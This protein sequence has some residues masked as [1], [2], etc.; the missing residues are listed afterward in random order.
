[1]MCSSDVSQPRR[2]NR[3]VPVSS[4]LYQILLGGCIAFAGC[5]NKQQAQGPQSQSMQTSQSQ[6]TASVSPPSLTEVHQAVERVFKSA[7]LIDESRSPSFV[8]GDFNGDRSEDI[9]VIITTAPGKVSDMNQQFPPWILKDPFINTEPGMTPLRVSERETLLALIHGYG[10]EGWH[11]SQA[12]QTYLLKNALGEKIET[13]TKAEVV[14]VNQG[15]KLPELKGDLISEI[16]RGKPGYLY[17]A[18]STYSWYDPET[19]QGEPIARPVHPGF[20]TRN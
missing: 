3:F 15:K 2:R 19:F 9:A 16:L 14:A 5:S 1:M 11:D 12:T 6:P 10:A 17:Y 4:F 7:A 20:A 13:R 8:V 18:G